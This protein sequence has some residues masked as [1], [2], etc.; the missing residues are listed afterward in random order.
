[1][2]ELKQEIV[3]RLME[4]DEH[5]FEEI[6][7][8]YRKLVFYMAI[9]HLKSASEAEDIVQEVFV[10]VYKNIN[11]IKTPQS[12][13]IWVNKITYSR[14]MDALRKRKEPY[15]DVNEQDVENISIEEDV[16]DVINRK[17]I[18]EV[19]Q[20]CLLDMSEDLKMVGLLRFYEEL[21]LQDISEILDVPIGT[22][23]SRLFTVKEQLRT[24]LKNHGFNKI[25]CML[26]LMPGNIK[27]IFETI[28]DSTSSKIVKPHRYAKGIIQSMFLLTGM[29]SLTI[30][31]VAMKNQSPQLKVES[32]DFYILYNKE[33]TNEDITLEITPK[34]YDE[35]HIDGKKSSVISK[36]GSYKVA[37]IKDGKIFHEQQI[38]IDTIDKNRPEVVNYIQEEATIIL[39]I[40][41][42]ESGVDVSSIRVIDD[43]QSEIPFE[44]QANSIQ[45]K[46]ESKRKYQVSAED[47]AGNKLDAFCYF[48]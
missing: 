15:V 11:K 20:K 25:A 45:F 2:T 1:M 27:Y 35:I 7:Q 48:Q 38:Q 19:I 41:D 21:P 34:D 30:G 13:T 9:T 3:N 47:L 22:I 32:P 4:G 18:N 6:Y 37:I 42:K 44:I 43:Q 24:K 14:C 33:I 23:K 39:N 10:D 40:E 26:F 31:A 29:L 46:S 16:M 17:Y 28:Q 5:A 12:L 8:H 36:N